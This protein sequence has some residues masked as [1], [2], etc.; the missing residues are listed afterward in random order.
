MARALPGARGAE[1][2][3]RPS[4]LHHGHRPGVSFGATATEWPTGRPERANEARAR[5]GTGAEHR[6][7]D[8]DR[9]DRD[10]VKL[11][12]AVNRAL[13]RGA[14]LA[15]KSS[16]SA[17]APWASPGQAVQTSERNFPHQADAHAAQSGLGSP[18]A[19]PMPSSTVRATRSLGRWASQR[20]ELRGSGGCFG[21]A[22]RS[23]RFARPPPLSLD[24]LDRPRLHG[25]GIESALGHDPIEEEEDG[26][27]KR[28]C[29]EG[30]L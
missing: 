16:H 27:G 11:H 17:L 9:P 21:E 18:L 4:E 5:I 25:E 22:F 26:D 3:R 13:E 7:P 28:G 29:S 24:L 14:R 30:R 20:S 12:E 1:S 8:N 15:E 6:G 23:I 2:S 10:A 19:I